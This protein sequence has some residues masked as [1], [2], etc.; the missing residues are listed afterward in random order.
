[1]DSPEHMLIG[2]IVRKVNLKK[3]AEELSSLGADDSPVACFIFFKIVP[4]ALAV[5]NSHTA[6]QAVCPAIVESLSKMNCMV[7]STISDCEV[8]VIKALT[9]DP[10]VF[11]V[12]AHLEINW[13]VWSVMLPYSFV[14]E[15]VARERLALKWGDLDCPSCGSHHCKYKF[16]HN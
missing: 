3:S 6:I 1:M 5:S 13:V 8:T 7:Y 4:L 12:F 10:T 16:L 14:F 11:W 15:P 2:I 9:S